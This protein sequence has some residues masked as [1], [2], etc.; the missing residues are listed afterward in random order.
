MM[1]LFNSYQ[2]ICMAT[3]KQLCAANNFVLRIQVV[4]HLFWRVP[5]LFT[6]C[7]QNLH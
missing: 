2:A 1:L 7:C 5:P 3:P 6:M 4:T